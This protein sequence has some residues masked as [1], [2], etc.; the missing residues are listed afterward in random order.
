MV[1]RNISVS[2]PPIYSTDIDRTRLAVAGDRLE[3]ARELLMEANQL[4]DQLVTTIDD[5]S[6]QFDLKTKVSEQFLLVQSTIT[7]I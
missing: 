6:E 1:D 7:R 4:C 2:F 3:Q 5:P